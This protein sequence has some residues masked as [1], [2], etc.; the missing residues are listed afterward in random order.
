MVRIT[1]PRRFLVFLII[2]LGLLILGVYQILP[3]NEQ[4]ARSGTIL[5]EPGSAAQSVWEKFKDDGFTSSTLPWQFY[6]WRQ[7]A[8]GRLQAGTYEI[9]R[10]ETVPA[11]IGRLVSGDTAPDAL[12]IT[13][14]EGFTLNQMAERTAAK[15]IGTAQDFLQAAVPQPYAN[16][17]SFVRD[18]PANR[19]LEGYLFPDT[20]QFTADA[21]PED[22]IKRMLANFNRRLEDSELMT[23]AATQNRSLDEMITMASIIEREVFNDDDMKIVSGIL[24]KRN[25]EGIGLDADATIRYAL[26]K[27]NQPLTYDDL[28][29]T[30]PYNTRKW[31]GLPP[32]PISN[33][34]LRALTAA[35]SP[36]NTAY[37]YYLSTVEGETIFSETNDEHNANKAKYLN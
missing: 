5:V 30:S 18:I 12:T 23:K 25:D 35:A 37:Y 32:G 27:W 19:N 31:K 7:D 26:K 9:T 21:K 17:F 1:N 16:D 10:G 6:A 33:P 24:W 28:Q 14:P 15:G 22:V 20:Y 29:S 34:G 4:T 36:Q 13:Y 3:I 11:I 2:V 8:A